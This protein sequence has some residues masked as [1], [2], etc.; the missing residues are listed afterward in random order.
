MKPFVTLTAIAAPFD[1]VNIDTDQIIP[2]RFIRKPLGPDYHRYLFHDIRFTENGEERGD[3]ILN[4]PA[5]RKARII[6]ANRNFGCGSSREQA[7]FALDANHIRAVIAPSFGDIFHNNCFKNGLLPI[8][9]PEEICA[10]LRAQ[11]HEN[12]GAETIIDLEANRITAAD[13][14]GHNFTVSDFRSRCLL[15]GLD[16]IALTLEH[17]TA[18]DAF[19][20]DY[21]REMSWLYPAGNT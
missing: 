10:A 13:G 16:D 3:F 6:V 19:E 8:C 11:L 2:A 1:A 15:Q 7:V 17:K 21:R 12:P 14:T 5:Y 4:Q 9:L 18:I 20:T